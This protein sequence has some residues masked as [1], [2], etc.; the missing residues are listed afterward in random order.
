MDRH[1]ERRLV[2]LKKW[3]TTCS[4]ELSIDPGVLCPNS[5]LEAVAFRNP[6]KSSDL[7]EV[8]EL[9]RWFIREFGKQVAEASRTAE[10]AN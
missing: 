1:T 3:R 5:S 6:Q 8:G 2:A 7:E 9:K 4:K 10:N